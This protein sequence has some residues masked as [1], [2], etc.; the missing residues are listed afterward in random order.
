[1]D[2]GEIGGMDHVVIRQDAPDEI[3]EEHVVSTKTL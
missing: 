3:G 1:M 2:D